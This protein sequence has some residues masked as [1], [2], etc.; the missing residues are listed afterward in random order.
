M[1]TALIKSGCF[2]VSRVGSEQKRLK[3]IRWRRKSQNNIS[4][5]VHHEITILQ[6][7][8][9]YMPMCVLTYGV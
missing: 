2:L 5:S 3:R 7:E 4:S 9:V 8:A 6:L 1:E